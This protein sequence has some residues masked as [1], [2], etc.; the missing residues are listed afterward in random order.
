MCLWESVATDER[1][2]LCHSRT[3]AHTHPWLGDRTSVGL[4]AYGGMYADGG[5][6]TRYYKWEQLCHSGAV[7]HN[8]P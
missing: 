4:S 6:V 5:L 3:V 2:V 1:S 8:H 7:A